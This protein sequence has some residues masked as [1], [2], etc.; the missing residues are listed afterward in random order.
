MTRVLL[1]VA[2]VLA[3]SIGGGAASVWYAVNEIGGFGAL[4]VGSWTAY[5]ERGTPDAD[6]YSKARFARDAELPLGRAE[7]ISFV[8]A[9]DSSGLEL[10][11]RCTYRIEGTVPVS[12][13]WTLYAAANGLSPIRHENRRPGLQSL[14]ILRQPDNSFEIAAGPHPAPGNWLPLTG[15]GPMSLVLTLYDASALNDAGSIE[16]ELPRIYRAGCDA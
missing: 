9:K 12:R 10:R 13:F 5:P 1:S 4:H 16:L 2:L 11:R 6:P 7:G 8:A 15:E 14:Q 3:L